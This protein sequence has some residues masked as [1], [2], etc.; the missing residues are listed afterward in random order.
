MN[1]ICWDT[2]WEVFWFSKQAILQPYE[3]LIVTETEIKVLSQHSGCS[4]VST[5]I[6]EYSLWPQWL[7]AVRFGE[8][9][10]RATTDKKTPEC[11][12]CCL[13]N[14]KIYLQ[15]QFS[16]HC[17]FFWENKQQ[18][19]TFQE[20]KWSSFVPVFFSGFCKTVLLHHQIGVQWMFRRWIGFFWA[21]FAL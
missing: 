16:L 10:R 12:P 7:P 13:L 20:A 5:G 3:V 21:Y 8:G 1:S 2:W 18:D 19:I 14:T 17:L 6:F 4:Q 15:V 11:F 9:L